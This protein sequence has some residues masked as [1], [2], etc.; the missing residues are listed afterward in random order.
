MPIISSVKI[1]LIILYN[2][3]NLDM[4]PLVQLTTPI[5]KIRVDLI[6]IQAYVKIGMTLVIVFLVIAAFICMIVV[7]IKL[8][9]N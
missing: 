4:V 6:M 2:F 1:S 9:G 8:G 3:I 5:S 7:T